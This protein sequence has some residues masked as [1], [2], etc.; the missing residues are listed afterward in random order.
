[1]MAERCDGRA[2]MN[3]AP[4]CG[5]F[6][7][8]PRE[9]FGLRLPDELGGGP[10]DAVDIAVFAA[11]AT[12]ADA[13]RF[14]RPAIASLAAM[15]D[16][17]ADTVRRALNRLDAAGAIT[18]Q[19]R[20]DVGGRQTANG[21]VLDLL[22]S[23]PRGASMPGGA[24]TH[25]RGEGGTHARGDPCMG[26]TPRTVP[27]RTGPEEQ[28]SDTLRVSGAPGAPRPPDDVRLDLGDDA[29]AEESDPRTVLFRD[30][31][32]QLARWR[33]KS[34]ND[35]MRAQ[36]GRWLAMANDDARHV[37]DAMQAAVRINAAEPVAFVEGRL[38][39]RA[40]APT[41]SWA[42]EA[43]ERVIARFGAGGPS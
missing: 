34:P 32:A 41:K 43:A 11:L 14:A 9:L 18:R 13:D 35:G 30:G 17:S 1:M 27:V 4:Q 25:A 7:I 6:G 23:A 24:G 3:S 15:V 36:L 20:Y 33:R 42:T 8:V 22:K 38:R 2:S 37:L 10:L 19:A 40:S 28:G 29:A 5:A 12:F 39:K 16:R 31:L 26:A 21:Y